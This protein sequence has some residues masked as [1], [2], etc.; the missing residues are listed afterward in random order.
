MHVVLFVTGHAFDFNI[1]EFFVDM[2][3]FAGKKLVRT[4]QWKFRY[5]MIK[6][7]FLDPAFFVVALGAIFTL[8]PIMRIVEAMTLTTLHRWFVVK[9]VAFVTGLALQVFMFPFQ[10]KVSVFVVIKNTITPLFL[11]VATVA[12]SAEIP[13]VGIMHLVTGITDRFDSYF[14]YIFFVTIFTH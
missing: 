14:K 11:I 5:I 13:V 7:N 9:Q 2:A 6:N 3:I 1:L 10:F 8:L 4:M 12:A